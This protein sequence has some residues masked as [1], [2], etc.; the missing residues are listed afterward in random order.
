MTTLLHDEL[1]GER[2]SDHDGAEPRS[3]RANSRRT[4]RW[5]AL[6]GIGVAALAWYGSLRTPCGPAEGTTLSPPVVPAP[7]D[8]EI[9]GRKTFRVATFNI[10]GGRGTDG[11][12]DLDRTARCL[13]GVDLVALNEVRGRYF[14]Q[15]ADQAET[16]GQMLDLPWLFAPAER[17]WWHFDFGSAL[18]SRVPVAHWQRI[19]L[20]RTGGKTYRNLLLAAAE[21]D[22]RRVNFIIT[23]LDSRDPLRRQEQMRVVGDLFL[24]LEEPAL[25]LGDLNATGD[26]PQIER[27]LSMPGV[28]DALSI[29][30]NDVA[31]QRI[32]WIIARGLR[33]VAAGAV[34]DG[35]SDHPCLWAELEL[36]SAPGGT[37]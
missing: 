19:P 16:L 28:V 4:L 2:R 32:D 7:V 35:A 29:A 26:D 3:R 14:W 31:T 23:H 34:F 10:H 9:Q 24:S 20:A 22:G 18:L 21:F 15:E 12:R 36:L 27:V 6:A 1:L 25:L 8:A 30:P 17:R 11:V 33:P 13:A 37:P 5:F